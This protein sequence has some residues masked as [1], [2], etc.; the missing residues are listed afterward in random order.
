MLK[1]VKWIGMALVFISCSGIGIMYSMI[2]KQRVEELLEWKKGIT[3]LKSE[4]EFSL[5]PLSEA[6]ETIGKRLEGEIKKVFVALSL[7]LKENPHY[8]MD[9][10]DDKIIKGLFSEACLNEKDTQKLMS[11]IKN[12]GLKDK[13][14]Q[15][16]H[17]SLHIKNIEQDVETA[18]RDE[19]KNNKL[20]KTLGVL[21]GIFIVVI[22]I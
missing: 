18:K 16:N 5:T 2:Y 15:M 14:S 22:F 12:L 9:K 17:L 6:F 11:F 3:L 8:A 10:I 20:F 19:E 4:I 21:S 13:E 1:K 7:L